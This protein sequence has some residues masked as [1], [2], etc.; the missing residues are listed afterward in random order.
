MAWVQ[1]ASASFRARH[2]SAAAT[3]AREVL[4]SLEEVRLRLTGLFPT[5]PAG[6]TVIL[7]GG[8]GGLSL[9][10]PLLPLQRALTA[11]AAR[12]YVGCFAGN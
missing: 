7:H 6:L 1:T 11:P 2:D 8:L 10:A 9:A 12:R 3:D 4:E 5:V